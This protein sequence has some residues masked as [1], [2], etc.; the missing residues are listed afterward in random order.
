MQTRS[1]PFLL[2]ATVAASAALLGSPVAS[3]H[4]ENWP[5]WRGPRGD[6]SSLETNVP[7]HWSATQNVVWST[8]VPGEGHSSPVVWN[9]RV[10]TATAFPEKEERAL[11]CVERKT[12]KLLWQQTVLKAP[13]EKKQTEN[14]YASGTPATDGERV[15]V[16]FQDGNQVAVAAHDF[17]GKQLWL[18]HPGE[19]QTE[20]GFASSP[21]LSGDKVILA[22]EGQ[23][24]NF[25][26][27]L[28]RTDGHTIWKTALERPS[29]SFGQPFVRTL[30]G[31]EQIVLCGNKSVM[32]FD[33]KDGSLI[34]FTENAATDSVV[35]PVYNEKA[36]LVLTSTSWDKKEL[37]AIKP[38]GSG[39]VTSN[40][41]A[42]KSQRGGPYCPSP[43]SVGDYFLTVSDAG[44]EMYCFRAASGEIFWHEPFGHA[45]ASPVAVGSLVYFLNDK[46][47]MNVVRAAEKYELVASNDLGEKCFASPAIS[48]GQIFLRGDKHLFCIGNR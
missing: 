35:T 11:V 34:W 40:K 5:A 32:S 31:R 24:G 36:G 23:K 16:A 26:A 28:S 46:G 33:L 30:A 3:V 22:A 12:G 41:V 27:A 7:I 29:N 18:M 48:D 20:H 9:D 37:S 19:F 1:I 21:V 45:H 44:N 13:L 39:N 43:I 8:P 10:F 15:Y 2:T 47:L 4:A 17:S 6:G 14:S 42:W 25:L 38:D